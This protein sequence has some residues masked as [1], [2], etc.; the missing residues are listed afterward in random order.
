MKIHINDRLVR[1]NARLGQVAS[2]VGLLVW[3]VACIS[4]FNIKIW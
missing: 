3:L 2:L 4:H 1:R